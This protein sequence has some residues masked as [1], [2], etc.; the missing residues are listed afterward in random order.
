MLSLCNAASGSDSRGSSVA[1]RQTARMLSVC[2]YS[3]NP[4][5]KTYADTPIA[6]IMKATKTNAYS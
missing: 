1:E 6:N 3:V 5:K 2:P 4:N